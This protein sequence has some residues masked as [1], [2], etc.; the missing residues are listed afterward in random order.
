MK[1]LVESSC[2]EIFHRGLARRF[3]DIRRSCIEISFR[4]L[5]KRAPVMEISH[6]DL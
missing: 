2:K 1:D 3:R 4:G 6:R 5:V